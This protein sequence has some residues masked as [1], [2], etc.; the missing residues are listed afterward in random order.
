MKTYV[1]M[2]VYIYGFLTAALVE[3]EWLASRPDH[4]NLR[5]KAR[6]THWIVDWAGPRA[7]L[8]AVGKRKFLTL[9]G[10]ELRPLCCPG[11]T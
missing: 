3:S 10:I 1:V 6:V 7:G 2:D 5:V 9:P 11:R 8:K 4:F